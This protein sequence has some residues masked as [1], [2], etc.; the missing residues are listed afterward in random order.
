M[1]RQTE[2]SYIDRNQKT[3]HE[4]SRFN[5]G[6]KG[7]Q[8]KYK[9]L[10]ITKNNKCNS[11]RNNTPEKC[12]QGVPIHDGEPWRRTSYEVANPQHHLTKNRT[13]ADSEPVRTNSES[14]DDGS[15]TSHSV[16]LL[17]RRKRNE[18]AML[19]VQREAKR[20]IWPG[21]VEC[22][23]LGFCRARITEQW[24]FEEERRGMK[25]FGLCFVFKIIWKQFLS[26]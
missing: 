7:I 3:F 10:N 24:S 12:E 18:N 19:R 6:T 17:L 9:T 23:K 14:R 8:E 4:R 26:Q 16:F 1:T 15:E 2:N 20:E 21:E 22:E 11:S 13:V 25:L 5:N